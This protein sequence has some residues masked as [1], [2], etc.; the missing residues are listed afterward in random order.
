MV[1]F[2]TFSPD[3]AAAG[4]CLNGSGTLWSVHYTDVDGG[5]SILPKPGFVLGA[6]ETI[7]AQPVAT[8]VDG[9]AVE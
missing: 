2:S 1:Y 7:V 8:T 4:A 9:Q 5:A 3:A 6:G